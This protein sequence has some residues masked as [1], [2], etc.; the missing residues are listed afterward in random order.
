VA[1]ETVEMRCFVHVFGET[2]FGSGFKAMMEMDWSYFS[3]V[4]RPKRERA[5]MTRANDCF[6]CISYCGIL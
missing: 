5:E 2:L 4:A 6:V 3:R 1:V